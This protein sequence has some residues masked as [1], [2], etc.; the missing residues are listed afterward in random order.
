[1]Y[2]KAII[3]PH[4]LL[5]VNTRSEKEGR[6]D[7]GTKLE[8]REASMI[9]LLVGGDLSAWFFAKVLLK[10]HGHIMRKLLLKNNFFLLWWAIFFIFHPQMI[11]WEQKNRLFVGQ[12]Y[13]SKHNLDLQG[14]CKIQEAPLANCALNL[15]RKLANWLLTNWLLPSN[16]KKT[17]L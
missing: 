15:P 7:G 14:Y 10:I 2:R 13:W 17:H 6:H 4:S 12:N 9:V 11:K 5:C 3:I 1:M 8:T 16:T